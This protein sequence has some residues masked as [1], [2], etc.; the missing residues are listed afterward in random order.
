MTPALLTRTSILPNTLWTLHTNSLTGIR[1]RNGLADPSAA[2]CYQGNFVFQFHSNFL[3]RCILNC[4][5]VFPVKPMFW[6]ARD[7]SGA[8]K[9]LEADQEKRMDT[10]DVTGY[11]RRPPLLVGEHKGFFAKEG[12]EVKFHQ[13]TYAPDHNRGM[14]EGRWDMTLSS[15]DTMIART[16]TDG[17]DYL[18]FMQAEEGLSA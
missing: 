2:S 5:I 8:P 18:L 14:A 11:Q 4:Y 9:V 6:I 17:V 7:C 1:H 15:A 3:V 16:T 10:L 13:T 12:L